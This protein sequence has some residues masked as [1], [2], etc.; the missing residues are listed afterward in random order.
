MKSTSHP[1]SSSNHITIKYTRFWHIM[2]V[3]PHSFTHL[4]AQKALFTSS[5][6]DHSQISHALSK[7]I[8][9]GF[10]CRHIHCMFSGFEFTFPPP[11]LPAVLPSRN[12]NI[13]LPVPLGEDPFF[14]IMVTIVPET[15]RRTAASY[16][17][18]TVCTKNVC[19]FPAI[20]AMILTAISA[21]IC[22]PIGRPIGAWM[23]FTCS[24]VNPSLKKFLSGDPYFCLTSDHPEIGKWSLKDLSCTGGISQMPSRHNHIPGIFRREG[25][26][27]DKV[28]KIACD[29]FI[30]LRETLLRHKIFLS[31]IT[32]T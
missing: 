26:F 16:I 20:S 17:L 21:G 25:F 18:I 5:S 31:S 6:A 8:N 27:S 11:M 29:P 12:T 24:S 10:C 28:S 13:L 32:V 9:S 30:H 4:Q 23:L 19:F 15:P 2:Q 7:F 1:A 14:S 3:L 22:P